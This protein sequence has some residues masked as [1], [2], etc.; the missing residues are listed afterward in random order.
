MSKKS[1]ATVTPIDVTFRTKDVRLGDVHKNDANNHRTYPITPEERAAMAES[2]SKVGLIHPL[3]VYDMGTLN[4]EQEANL[5]FQ[6][7]YDLIAGFGRYDTLMEMSGPDTM[8]T[9]HVYACSVSREA[10]NQ[11]ENSR[12][13]ALSYIDK[14]RLIESKV[15]GGMTISAAAKEIGVSQSQGSQ[16]KALLTLSPKH[17]LMIHTGEIPW[18]T[19]RA[20]PGMDEAE[21][22]DTIERVK[23]AAETGTTAT[24]V[25]ERASHGRKKKGTRGKKTTEAGEKSST[26][27][28]ITSK[29]ALLLIE[30]S[31]LESKATIKA[32]EIDKDVSMALGVAVDHLNGFAKFLRGKVGIQKLM[33]DLTAAA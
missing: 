21:R 13:R 29:K 19:A 25:T 32:G 16:L 24:A 31:I 11:E 33:K 5:T 2:I 30:E 18:R 15:T 1:A 4:I 22:A 12:T 3:A 23:N 14:A 26:T 9:V 17:Q 28:N 8:V 7:P 20:L 10:V 6:E 27:G